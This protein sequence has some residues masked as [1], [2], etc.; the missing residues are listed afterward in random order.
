MLALVVL[1][2]PCA[3]AQ[4]SDRPT[5]LDGYYVLD[6][7]GYY[8]K[9]KLADVPIGQVFYLG[10]RKGKWLMANMLSGYGGT[11]KA[12]KTG[13]EFLATEGPSGKIKSVQKLRVE[14]TKK[15][16]ATLGP[17]PGSPLLKFSFKSAAI[18]SSFKIE[19]FLAPRRK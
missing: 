11:Y 13:F 14:R 6:D 1:V 12:L 19:E 5:G 18:P 16:L 3:F 4:K 8:G 15:G 10:V 17:T 7:P 2:S 9:A